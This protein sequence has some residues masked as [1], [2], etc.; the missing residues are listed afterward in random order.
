MCVAK[1][2]RSSLEAHPAATPRSSSRGSLHFGLDGGLADFFAVSQLHPPDTNSNHSTINTVC[3]IAGYLN[4][5]PDDGVYED[6]KEET[7]VFGNE[8]T[9]SPPA[10][11][12][13]FDKTL[14]GGGSPTPKAGNYNYIRNF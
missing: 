8:T 11:T 4:S 6:W 5:L 14:W 7:V 1:S 3:G 10:K 13:S 12:I 2:P 9:P